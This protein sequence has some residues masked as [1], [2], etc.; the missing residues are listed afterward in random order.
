MVCAVAV[1]V[2]E[3]GMDIPPLSP[4][5]NAIVLAELQAGNAIT[6]VEAWLPKCHT[7]VFLAR[8]FTREY[9]VGP[10]IVFRHVGDHHYWLAEYSTADGG[11]CVACRF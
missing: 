11:E 7:L 8:P 4:G 10:D 2:V 9:S 3:I 6:S 1:W 5:L